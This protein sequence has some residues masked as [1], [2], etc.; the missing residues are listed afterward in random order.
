MPV[1]R[2]Q[3]PRAVLPPAWA[4][5]SYQAYDPD[6]GDIV[7]LVV[8]GGGRVYLRNENGE[9]VNQGGLRDG[10][11]PGTTASARYLAREGPGVLVGD[12][13]TGKHFYF[14]RKDESLEELNA[15]CLISSPSASR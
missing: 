1:M 7:Q 10:S 14:R 15:E 9:V 11:S 6:S 2:R 8:D 3:L 5:G 13:D 12:I 4:I